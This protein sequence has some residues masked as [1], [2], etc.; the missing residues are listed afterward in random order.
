M[1]VRGRGSWNPRRVQTVS[2]RVGQGQQLSG[3]SASGALRNCV[4]GSY[5]CV[6]GT[7]FA[8]AWASAR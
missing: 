6:R 2:N 4:R 1:G 8:G 3:A 5:A 7:I